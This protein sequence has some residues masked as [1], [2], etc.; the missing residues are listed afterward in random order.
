[1]METSRPGVLEVVSFVAGG[2]RVAVEAA[3]V[4]SQLPANHATGIAS[5][6]QL[7][8]L[9]EPESR[10]HGS[11]RILLLKHP[12]GDFAVMVSDPVELLGLAIDAIHPLPALIAARTTVAGLRGLAV[13]AEGVLLL[14]DF[15]AVR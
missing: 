13:D 4:H 5:A 12:A 2:Y 11:R 15:R 8:G 1:M 3:Q 7:L 14:V 9:P 6:E 10:E